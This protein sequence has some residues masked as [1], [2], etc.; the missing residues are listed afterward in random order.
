MF[1][2]ANLT[3]YTQW[4]AILTGI[5]AVITGLAWIW[6]WGIRFRLVGVTSFMG[7]ITGSIFGLSVGL[8]T[9][10]TIPGAVH[11]TRVFDTSADQVV[12]AVEPQI[13]ADQL[14]ATLQ[15]AAIDLFSRGRQSGGD[16]QLTIRARTMVHPQPGVSQPLY[17]GEVRRSLRQREDDQT[18]VTIYTENLARLPKLAPVV[19][20]LD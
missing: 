13:T 7:V 8:Y 6:Q 14:T 4:A 10:P 12:I 2:T 16:N 19:P 17:L 3:L 1:S 9:R 5:L 20:E 11:F 15:Q 18:K